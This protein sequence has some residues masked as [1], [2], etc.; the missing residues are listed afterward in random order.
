M[1]G[2]SRTN[3]ESEILLVLESFTVTSTNKVE[4]ALSVESK[5]LQSWKGEVG[6]KRWIGK[7]RVWVV[8][9]VNKGDNNG[10]NIGNIAHHLTVAS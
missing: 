10:T 7:K 5:R 8:T 6:R 1:K 4:K 2:V 3:L 9:Q